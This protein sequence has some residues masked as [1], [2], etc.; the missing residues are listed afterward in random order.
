MK[1]PEIVNEEFN[2]EKFIEGIAYNL[3]KKANS[4]AMEY[5]PST[6]AWILK[7]A[8]TNALMPEKN[9]KK[10]LNFW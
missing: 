9:S 1:N 6:W 4:H 2:Q 8:F 3:K 7:K 5:V 10:N